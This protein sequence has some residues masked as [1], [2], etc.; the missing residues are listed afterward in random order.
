MK[1]ATTLKLK[2]P[3]QSFIDKRRAE[4][5]AKFDKMPI[6]W[7]DLV[8]EYGATV[9]MA[10]QDCGAKDARR[11]RHIVE[12]VLNELSPVRSPSANQGGTP[13]RMV[14]V[15]KEPTWAMVAASMRTVTMM[16]AT[17]TKRKKHRLRLKAAIEVAAGKIPPAKVK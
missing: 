17:M 9:V 10:L 1:F 13:R 14:W 6:E 4:R 7:R 3:P 11:G 16:D 12:T 2:R 8:H 5:M 15:P